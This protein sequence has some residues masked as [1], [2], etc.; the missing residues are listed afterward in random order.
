LN[1]GIHE[2][3]E[4]YGSSRYGNHGY[5]E[6]INEYTNGN[7]ETC[8][9]YVSDGYVRGESYHRESTL[10]FSRVDYRWYDPAQ[11]VSAPRYDHDEDRYDPNMTVTCRIPDPRGYRPFVGH[12]YTMRDA[13]RRAMRACLSF[14]PEYECH[15]R[16]YCE[17][18][19]YSRYPRYGRRY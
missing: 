11:Y 14:Y 7:G 15:A 12:G 3:Q 6:V 19:E 10:C 18:R 13:S 9:Q 1:G 5:F 16:Q 8:R 4:W 2:R 17:D